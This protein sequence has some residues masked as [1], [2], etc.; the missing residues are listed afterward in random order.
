MKNR[1]KFGRRKGDYVNR[2]LLITSLIA[3]VIVAGVVIGG[4]VPETGFIELGNK[5]NTTDGGGGTTDSGSTDG[6]STDGPDSPG[7]P[8]TKIP[9]AHFNAA[10]GTNATFTLTWEE[11]G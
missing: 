8:P 1:R 7:E 11:P 3:H 2:Y 6:G 10:E 5:S 9:V 4:C